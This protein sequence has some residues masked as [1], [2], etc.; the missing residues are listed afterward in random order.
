MEYLVSER[1]HFDLYNESGPIGLKLDDQFMN[2][3]PVY[4]LVKFAISLQ[5]SSDSG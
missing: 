1:H 2:Q 4:K 3:W 5:C